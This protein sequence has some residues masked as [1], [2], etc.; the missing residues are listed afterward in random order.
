[1]DAQ[2][3]SLF[4]TLDFDGGRSSGKTWVDG[5]TDRSSTA[6]SAG[7]RASWEADFFGSNRH[8]ILGSSADAEAAK[9][10]LYSAHASLASVVALA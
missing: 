10:N 3:S 2:R 4:P 8:A 7:L 9:E 5:G 1:R 6:Y